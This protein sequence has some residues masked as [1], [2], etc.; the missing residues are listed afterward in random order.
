MLELKITNNEH[1]KDV[2]LN[3][4]IGIRLSLIGKD[5]MNTLWTKLQSYRRNGEIQADVMLP[6]NAISP[7]DHQPETMAMTPEEAVKIAQDIFYKLGAGDDVMVSNVYY[8]E[9]APG[10]YTDKINC[11]GIELKRYI[12]GMPIEIEFSTDKGMEKRTDDFSDQFNSGVP[13]EEMT[14]F[15]SDEG[16]LDLEW[17]EPIEQVEVLNQNAE[18]IPTE[19]IIDVF[20]QEF[21]NAYSFYDKPEDGNIIYNLQDIRLNYGIARIPNQNDIYMA[22]P[23]WEFYAQY[24]ETARGNPEER[25]ITL[26]TINALDKS[27]FSHQWGY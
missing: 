8:V 22:I 20:K 1:G 27:R 3:S 10:E 15:I 12:G 14:V 26:L 6:E 23:L 11:Y 5:G 13:M 25:I 17:K 7:A 4:S 9:I 2:A 24:F 21:R 18:L 19:E 16:I